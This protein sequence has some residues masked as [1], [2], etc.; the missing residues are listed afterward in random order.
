[1]ELYD[2]LLFQIDSYVGGIVKN[3]FEFRLKVYLN[4]NINTD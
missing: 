2:L 3:I 4:I 1:M